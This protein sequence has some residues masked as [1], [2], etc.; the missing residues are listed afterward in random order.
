VYTA[1]WND[2]LE[3][4]FAETGWALLITGGSLKMAA[5]PKTIPA[6]RSASN[7]T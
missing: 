7:K 1:F 4:A 2:Q 6:H 5:L 3:D